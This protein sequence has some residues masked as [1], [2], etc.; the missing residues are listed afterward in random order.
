MCNNNS[1]EGKMPVV[2]REK[3]SSAWE[4]L[5]EGI[6]DNILILSSFKS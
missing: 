6:E 3:G 2:G 5:E 1:Q 4:A